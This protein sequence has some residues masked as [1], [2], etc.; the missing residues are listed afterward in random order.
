[1]PRFMVS[2]AVLGFFS[3]A[4]PRSFAQDA[5]ENLHVLPKDVSC[6]SGSRAWQVGCEA[7]G[8][9]WWP[10]RAA[11]SERAVGR[12]D[13]RRRCGGQASATVEVV[14]ARGPAGHGHQRGAPAYQ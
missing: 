8:L 1:M 3:F 10:V 13:Q 11:P 7:A 12:E 9:Q 2:L 14:V 6:P 4:A 5:F